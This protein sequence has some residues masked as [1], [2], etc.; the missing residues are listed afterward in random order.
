[1]TQTSPDTALTT[2]T[3]DSGGNLKT[4]TDARSAI[5]TYNYDVLNR[6]TGAAF[7]IGA[8]TDQTIT[9]TY[10]AGTNGKGH[11]TG[12]SDGNHTIAWNY[13]SQ[14]RVTARG[15]RSGATVTVRGL[16][17][18]RLRSTRAD[19]TALRET[20]FSTATARTGR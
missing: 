11:L 5:T 19:G 13:D 17:L 14:G 18:Q 4:S 8:S 16:R 7:K 9:Y 12:A 6:V 10:D 3:Y 1:M 15:S 2:N 20:P